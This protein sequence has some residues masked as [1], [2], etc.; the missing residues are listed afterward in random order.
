MLALGHLFY[1]AWLLFLIEITG[2][3]LL[4]EVP[5][6]ISLDLIRSLA[7]HSRPPNIRWELAL[8]RVRLVAIRYGTVIVRVGLLGS[9]PGSL[10]AIVV[11]TLPWMRMLLEGHGLCVGIRLPMSRIH[12]VCCVESSYRLRLR[13]PIIALCLSLLC[14]FVQH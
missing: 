7:P 12:L 13:I 10:G 9:L 4:I 11:L 3:V 1:V 5:A 2:Y 6:K 14:R 8:A